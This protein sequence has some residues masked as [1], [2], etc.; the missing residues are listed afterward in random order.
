MPE[1]WM[2]TTPLKKQ[3]GVITH[4]KQDHIFSQHGDWPPKCHHLLTWAR[5]STKQISALARIA[6]NH[7][8]WLQEALL[9]LGAATFLHVSRIVTGHGLKLLQIWH[10]FFPF[11]S[12]NGFNTFDWVSRALCQTV[13][14][15]GMLRIK[16][17][18][19]FPLIKKFKFSPGVSLNKQCDCLP[20]SPPSVIS[21]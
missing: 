3:H 8:L 7:L 9:P 10:L 13:R 16:S 20:F 18:Q 5:C 11:C 12:P 14:C 2:C 4:G 6:V 19:H 21:A 17:L 1:T 15:D